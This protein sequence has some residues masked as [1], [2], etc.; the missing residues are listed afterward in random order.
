MKFCNPETQQLFDAL[1]RNTREMIEVPNECLPLEFHNLRDGGRSLQELEDMM[2]AKEETESEFQKVKAEKARRIEI[3]RQQWEENPDSP[4]DY[5][6]DD[7]KLYENQLAFAG[8]M[9]KAGVMEEFDEED[10]WC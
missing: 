10:F 2:V 7:A 6:E 5:N 8:A 9:I 3:L 1:A 4:L